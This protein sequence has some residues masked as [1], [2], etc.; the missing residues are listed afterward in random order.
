MMY[1]PFRCA[2]W[3]EIIL[4]QQ[5]GRGTLEI[6]PCL[7]MEFGSSPAL[8]RVSI[9]GG[10]PFIALI[11]GGRLQALADWSARRGGVVWGCASMQQMLEHWPCNAQAIA[12]AVLDDDQASDAALFRFH[13]PVQPSSVYC[14][15]GNYRAQLLQAALDNDEASGETAHSEQSRRERHL[16]AIEARRL[17]EPYVVAKPVSS[18]CGPDDQLELEAG[19]DTLDWEVE[20]G[21]VIGKRARYVSA[22]EALQYVAGYCTVND[23]TLRQRLF[24]LEPK[25]MGTDFLQ[26]KGGPGWLPIGPLLVPASAVA[27]PQ[28]MELRLSL[29]GQVMQEGHSSDMLFCIAEQIAY[30]S[31]HVQ[32]E[33]GD[34]ICTGSP[35]GFGSHYRRFLRE[36]DVIEAEVRGVGAQRT[37]VRS[38]LRKA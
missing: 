26:A 28:A 14:T 2:E 15:I 21:V 16:A 31:R 12:H 35:A 20:I 3:V 6:C 13:A 23:I 19:Q 34:L 24:R 25:G 1:G 4:R 36:G 9:A 18:L 5:G 7:I 32:L 30:L 33:P 29:N 22:P 10:A 27:D 37:T 8:A 17:G 38:R 11:H